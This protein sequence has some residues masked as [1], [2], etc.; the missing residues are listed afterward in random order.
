M[1]RPRRH[2]VPT[3]Q[4]TWG[5]WEGGPC[6]GCFQGAP[7]VREGHWC[8]WRGVQMLSG[9][10]LHHLGFASGCCDESH[11]WQLGQ[12]WPQLMGA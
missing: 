5:G 2:R 12:A 7:R 4:H 1:L 3:T 11:A 8:L 9:D 10:T 6:P